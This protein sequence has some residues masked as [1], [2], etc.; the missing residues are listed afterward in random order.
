MSRSLR[1]SASQT[2]TEPLPAASW[3]DQDETAA[4]LPALPSVL[5]RVCLPDA[6]DGISSCPNTLGAP[7]SERDTESSAPCT[8]PLVPLAPCGGKTNYPLTRVDSYR[9]DH[10]KTTGTQIPRH[11]T[12]RAV[13]D[14]KYYGKL[15]CVRRLGGGTVATA[16]PAQGGTMQRPRRYAHE[17]PCNH[18]STTGRRTVPV[19]PSPHSLTPPCSV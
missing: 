16:T 2:P 6:P 18:D 15:K 7:C 3:A 5:R 11:T 14:T 10:F 13:L 17:S 1:A 9:P 12:Q 4:E 19:S 8:A